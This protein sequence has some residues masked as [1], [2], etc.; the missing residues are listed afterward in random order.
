MPRKFARSAVS[1]A[2]RATWREAPAPSPRAL[3]AILLLVLG[4]AVAAFVQPVR[5]QLALS[6]TRQPSQYSE[7]YFTKLPQTRAGQLTLGFRIANHGDHDVRYRYTIRL[8]PGTTPGVVIR[9]GTRLVSPNQRA[10][11]T[12][13][14]RVRPGAARRTATVIVAGGGSKEIRVHARLVTGSAQ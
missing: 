3:A 4:L 2:A 6:F 1:D 7:L 13:T 11:I 14:A 8:A 10:D 5:H 9:S 12:V